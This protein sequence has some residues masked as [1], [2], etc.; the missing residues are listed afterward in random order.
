[1]SSDFIGDDK[2]LRIK[3]H[4]CQA[5]ELS[6][7]QRSPILLPTHHEFTTLWVRHWH[8]KLHHA[9]VNS[10]LAAIRSR[11]WIV[12]GKQRVRILLHSC[13][14]CRKNHAKLL[15]PTMG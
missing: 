5:I 14:I 4:L 6:F 10:V 11:Y 3:G 7:H 12:H 13:I 2:L 1:M 15:N 9:G 8:L